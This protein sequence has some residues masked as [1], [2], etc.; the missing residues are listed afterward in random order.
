MR[1]LTADVVEFV[2]VHSGRSN[3][4]LQRTLPSDEERRSPPHNL[5]AEQALLGAILVHNE[6]YDRVSGFLEPHHFYDP[7]HQQIYETAAR[8]IEEGKCADPITLKQFFENAEPID[9]TLTVSQYLGRLGCATRENKFAATLAD[10]A[11]AAGWPSQLT[12]AR[13][14]A[15]DEQVRRQPVAGPRLELPLHDA[16]NPRWSRQ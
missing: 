12:A 16:G 15:K 13:A 4:S 5:K 14:C 6:A 3:R 10:S 9:A 7:L 8:L 1:A 11:P 2:P